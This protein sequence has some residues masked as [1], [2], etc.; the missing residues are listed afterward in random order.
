MTDGAFGRDGTFVPAP[1]H[2]TGVLEESWWRAAPGWF[3]TP[4]R[5][6]DDAATAMPTWPHSGFGTYVGPRIE[7]DERAGL[8]RVARYEARAL[9]LHNPLREEGQGL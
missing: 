4:G 9:A 6:D 1:V 5:L 8:L 7:S 3:V 2:E